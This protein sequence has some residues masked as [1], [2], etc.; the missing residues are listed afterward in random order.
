M[1]LMKDI[2]EKDEKAQK[3]SVIDKDTQKRWIL[4]SG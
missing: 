2:H 4:G 3:E 1:L